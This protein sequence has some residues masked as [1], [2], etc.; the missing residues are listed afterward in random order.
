MDMILCQAFLGGTKAVAR[1]KLRFRPAVYGLIMDGDKVLLMNTILTGNYSLPG[2]GVELGERL[3]DAL[4]REVREETGL[5][6][7]VGRFAGFEESFFYYDPS[8]KAYH[9]FRFYY[10]CR[11][12]SFELASKD[13][14]EDDG[15]DQPQWVAVSSLRLE[16]F[17][18][19]GETILAM[20]RSGIEQPG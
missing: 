10:F 14:I 5:A 20:L 9:S 13:E 1:E 19:H 15:V 12:L 3:E 6:V 11:P 8:G 4:G 16:D 2:G 7:E 17:H 18:D